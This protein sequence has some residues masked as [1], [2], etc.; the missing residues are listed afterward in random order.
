MAEK[1]LKEIPSSVCLVC[2][3]AFTPDDIIIIN[4]RYLVGLEMNR[5]DEERKVLRQ[6][7]LA[8]RKSERKSVGVSF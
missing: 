4:G 6:R 3:K 8:R 5:S 1:A 2:G 7:M